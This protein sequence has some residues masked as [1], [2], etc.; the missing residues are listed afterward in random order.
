MPESNENNP[1]KE[2]VDRAKA[3]K[4]D[5]EILGNLDATKITDGEKF[6]IKTKH[7]E[8]TLEKRDGQ[9][10]LSGG[11]LKM[12]ETDVTGY[13]GSNTGLFTKDIIGIGM[14]MEFADPEH[15]GGAITTSRVKEIIPIAFKK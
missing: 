15:R 11:S 8:Y 5:S 9:L 10:F 7:S 4:R 3:E 13:F 6:R 14:K 2:L 12:P 1:Y